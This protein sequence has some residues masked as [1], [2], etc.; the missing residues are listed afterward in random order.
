MSK[1]D[2][3]IQK[4]S[5]P[6]EFPIEL[7][8]RAHGNVVARCPLLPGCQAQGKTPKEALEQLKNVIDLYFTSATPAFFE[9]LEEFK[10][11]ST[12][13]D[14]A[15]YRGYLYAATGQD[16]ILRS[17]S[18]APGSWNKIPVTK[19]SPKFFSTVG[20]AKE[21]KGDYVTQIYCL[22]VYAPPGKEAV[23][24]AGT[25]L[26]GGIYQ[27][28]DGENWKEAFSTDE[29]RIH[30]LF[31]FKGRLYAGT[32]S[33]GKIFAFD[34]T[35]WNTVG[36]LSEVA[37]TCL[38][39]FQDRIFAGTYPS[40][41]IFASADGLNWE[42]MTATGQ[43]FIQCFQEFNGALYA[44]TSSPKGVKI[45]RTENGLDWLCVYETAR[46]L[47]LYCM[48][49]FENA[50]YAG[51]GNSGRVLK[52]QDGNDWKTAF[53]GD[54]EGVRTF[55]LFGDYLYAG[56]EN[57]GTLLRSTFDMARM[58]TIS[59]LTVEKLSSSSALLTWTTDI[60]ATSEVHYGEK[61]ESQDLRKVIIDKGMNLRHRVH[62]TDLKSEIEYEFKAVSAY[63][64]SSLT[65]SETAS[66]KTPPVPP[67]SITS[68]SHSQPGK[69]E[70]SS[71][72]EILLHPSAPLSG[73]YYFL[74]HYPETLPA[75]L[76]AS[77]TEDKRVALSSTPQGTWYFHVVGV[78]EAGN[79]GSQAS[80][81]KIL[82]DTE[83]VPPVSVTSST[84]PE[85]EKWVAN[86]TPVI[87]WEAPKDLSGIKGYFIKA[88]HEPTTVPGPGSGEFTQETRKTL[89][90]FED[91]FW[92]L[93]I[94]TQDEA[95]NVGNRAAHYP[96]RIDTKALAPTLTSTSHP[97]SDQWYS[98][99]QVEVH[100]NPPHD[101][102]G[103]EGYYY[104]IDHEP[105]TLPDPETAQW[106]EK[107]KITFNEIQDGQWF[108]HVRTKDKAENISPQAGHIKIC[109]DTLV[110]PPQVSSSTHSETAHWYRDRRVVLNWEDPFEH[111]GIEGY[112][113]NIDRKADTVPN[114]ENSLFTSQRMVS[115]ELTDDGLWYF[116]ITTKDKA[117][118]VDWKAVHY[119]LHVDTEVGR[120]FISSPSHPEQEQW[121]SKPKATFR[122]T[123]PDDLSGITGF[124]YSFSED[125]KI[126]PDPKSSSFTDKNEIT[127]D[128]P[129][130]GVH[131]LSVVC[132]DVAG[133]ISKEIATF[134]VRLDTLAES[135]VI[136]S[137]SHPQLEKWYGTRRVEFVWKDPGDLSGIDGYYY[138]INEDENW[139]ADLKSMTWTTGRGTVA[140]VAEDGTWFLHVCAKDKAGNV[141]V[142][143]H[144]KVRVDSEAGL[145]FIKSSTH[146]PNQW[147][148][149]TA[150]KFMWD[151]PREQSG[152]EGYYLSLD[153]Q[154]HTIPG[155]GNGKWVTE[156]SL[157]APALK[158]G[159]WFFHVN[160]KDMVGNVG[161]E[162]AHYPFL[163]DT[164][165]PKSQMKPLS[166]ILDKTQIYVEW[167]STDAHSGIASYDVQVK[168]D[169]GSWTDWLTNVTESNGVYQGQDGKR[170]AF[171]CRAKDNAGN[172]EV[173]PEG[174]MAA[175][176][177]DISPPAAVTQL[178]G[179]P[180][181]AGDIEL[182]W[183]PVADKISGTD[184]YRVYRWLEGGKK[185]KI[186]TDG[187]V[188]ETVFTDKGDGLKE[189]T[190]YYYCVQAVDR[191][192]NEQHEG[193]TTAASLSDHGVGVPTVTSPTH[194]SDDWSSQNSPVLI[195][196]APADATGIAGY[197]YLLD[198]SPNAKP[199][200]DPSNFVDG[201]RMELSNLESGIWY[202]HLVAKDRAGN[203]SEQ[204]AHYRLKIDLSK[205]SSPQITSTTHPDS[206]RWYA[207]NKIE[208]RI[209]S[210]PKLSGVE[211]FY[212]IFDRKADT[213]PLP[214]EAQRTTES[215]VSLKSSEPGVWYFHAV[216]KD[217]AGNLSEPTH[218]VVLVAAG[219]M[220]PPVVA[221]PTHPT[222]DEAVNHTEPL[223]TWDDRHD[224]SYK[225]MGYIYKFSPN[226]S[227]TLTSEDQFTTERSI[228]LRDIQ[229]G[230]WYFHV[231][232]VGKKG[233]PGLLSSRR[234][235]K[236]QRLGKVYGTFLRKD[237]VTPVSGT[238]LEMVK[239]DKVAA[240][241]M[242]DPKGRFNFSGLPEGKYEIRL[243][244]DQ[245]PVLRIKDIT[246]SVEEG[247]EEA[248]FTED[249][250][251]FP[252]P[253]KPG[254]LRFFYFLK[255]DC[256]VT[257]EIFDSTGG[258]VGKVEEKREG[259]AYAVT[260]WDAAGKPEGEYLYK[261]SAK[262]IT[263]NTMSRFSVKKFRI[264]KPIKEL[265]PQPVS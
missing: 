210:A 215:T 148:K 68:P 231:A 31:E 196:D 182:K 218:F 220:P 33:K 117:G 78:D 137:P 56:T 237:G 144:F 111:S 188:K 49:V 79:V 25:N 114:G 211:S 200:A 3:K 240:S 204:A 45:Y 162:A 83:A 47:N 94:S 67:P 70:K 153:S 213:R 17:S 242:T 241:V 154:P 243:H 41:L 258:M 195:W 35:Q 186:S 126:T 247:L 24:Y 13:Y 1:K 217:K 58:P 86:P 118:N 152:V 34:G 15:E 260:I 150:P 18:G 84:H 189:N 112:Y 164:A 80:H 51:T 190:V 147:V 4:K 238:K 82:I 12:L 54:A 191:I 256:N 72:I 110:S 103:V 21:G 262:S 105:M 71:D 74:N 160:V 87:A 73:F 228:Q 163:I 224:G 23:L 233:K 174:E 222:E 180:K 257:L 159:K 235:V 142:C 109:V 85:S 39:V 20:D 64:T 230:T 90:P 14:L 173:Y 221:S 92:Y 128:I 46:E 5:F 77:Y 100:I 254:P 16:L 179:M 127:L 171:R 192:G 155:P 172:V 48:E 88:D 140:T 166:A 264:Q 10:D 201:R 44:G 209:D 236:I 206:Q 36:S 19:T 158:D 226:E 76:E 124:Y 113:Y 251:I 119:P 66:F 167:S 214:N 187:Q 194:S 32:S 157:V 202:F 161:K 59:E 2:D 8:T 203:I 249:L 75:P 130:D 141:S 43:N 95:G 115:F 97:Q 7:E 175:T 60:S 50:L 227:E 26:S 136:T 38:G 177:P 89:G 145:A 151:P 225:P 29:D 208:F 101:L 223:F 11:I 81:F 69:W 246:V 28:T 99:N 198:Q 37:V 104:G 216:V 156:T 178:K 181:A 40:G 149:T 250:G 212:Y 52:T 61:K 125:P 98:N 265:A 30:S 146:P 245:F 9:S 207:S 139:A 132:Q 123:P 93:H 63:R 27:T 193:N 55:G 102:S 184:Y 255:E 120:A 248:V 133:N 106:T 131:I 138:A 65:V 129:R 253:P 229:E 108:V 199:S 134:R 252:Q 170:H 53:A 91:G 263:K 122:L 96:V 169:N 259:G 57:G 176:T 234:Q 143:A 183:N 168:T 185:E 219:E 116:H 239:G 135:P 261:L 6:Y 42:E 62:L 121:Y 22:C 107:T 232:A 205:P 197:Y 165:P 244:S